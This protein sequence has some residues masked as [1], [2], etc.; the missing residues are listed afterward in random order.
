[1][2]MLIRDSPEAVAKVGA[3]VVRKIIQTKDKT[4]LGLWQLAR[5]LFECIRN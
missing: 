3:S 2:G 4:V 1:M 5:H